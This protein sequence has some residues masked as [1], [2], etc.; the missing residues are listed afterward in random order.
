MPMMNNDTQTPRT[1]DQ[2]RESMMQALKAND[3]EGYSKCFDE[4][5]QRVAADL[6]ADNEQRM[7][8]MLQ[9]ADSA[10]LAQRGVRQLTS[11]ERK[12]YQAVIDAMRS[13]DP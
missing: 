10:I 9:S 7:E 3:A 13:S 5:M 4:M 6:T 1:R 2:I 12:Y 11:E 8:E